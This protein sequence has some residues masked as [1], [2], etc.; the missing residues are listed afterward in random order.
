MVALLLLEECI[1]NKLK[2][3]PTGGYMCGGAKVFL[4]R[5]NLA[6]GGKHSRRHVWCAIGSGSHRVRSTLHDS[7]NQNEWWE[8]SNNG[9][10]LRT[11]FLDVSR[12]FSP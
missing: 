3:F 1:S 9:N 6:A 5:Q 12:N 8:G 4:R 10:I 7:Q 11:S 2:F